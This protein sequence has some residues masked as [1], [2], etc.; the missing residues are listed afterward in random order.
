M[1]N[2]AL[3]TNQRLV[4]ALN[5]MISSLSQHLNGHIL[6]DM[7]IFDQNSNKIE[8]CLAGGRKTNFYFLV[9]HAHKQLEHLEFSLW[10]HRVNQCLIAISKVNGAPSWSFC[11]PLGW[12]SAIGKIYLDLLVKRFVAMDWHRRRFLIV[13]HQCSPRSMEVS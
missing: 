11:Y 7:S 6:G 4:G 2:Y 13:L 12:P 3:C 5:Q 1:H 10:R 8:I 9:A